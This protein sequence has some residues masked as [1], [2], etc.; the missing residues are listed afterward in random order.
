MKII[1]LGWPWMSLTISTVGY[2]S[3]SW[4]SCDAWH[5]TTACKKTPCCT[6]GHRLVVLQICDTEDRS[7]LV[8][9]K[10][11]PLAYSADRMTD[12][13]RIS[14]RRLC[15]FV[16]DF[17][18]VLSRTDFHYSDTNRFVANFWRTLSQPSRHVEMV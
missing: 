7:K 8:E 6:A 2:P 15:D 3:N 16:A 13:A 18:R 5:K 14:S 4:A 9:A 11:K 12:K 1:D 10:L 17:L